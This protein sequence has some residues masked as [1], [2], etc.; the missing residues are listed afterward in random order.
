MIVSI[1]IFILI[2]FILVVSHEFGHF[3][4]AKKN[5]IHVTEFFVG[6][7]PVLFRFEKGGTVYSWR[8]FPIGGACVFEGLAALDD[9][10]GEETSG[11]F[12][13]A[14]VWARFATLLAGP[15]FN[16]ILAYLMAVIIVGTCGVVTPVVQ[17]VIEDSGAE[18]AGLEAGDKI[19]KING[20]HVYLTEDVSFISQMNQR[21]KALTVQYERAGEKYTTVVVPKFASE[22]GR[23]YMGITTGEYLKCNAGQTFQ[24]AF[25][26]TKYYAD[27]VFKSLEMLVMGQLTKDD[28]AGPVGIV[29]IVDETVD[30]YSQYGIL[31]VVLS[32]VNLVLA[33][34]VNLGIINLLPLPA[35]D[36]G[37]LLFVVVEMIRRKPVPVEKEGMVHL[38]GM[39]AFLI[40]TVFVMFNDITRFL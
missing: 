39:V 24:Y 13:K 29:K 18:A 7:G 12:Y 10:T 36:G 1:L 3:L 16:F 15:M 26:T 21:G 14:N 25:Y 31:E 40:L 9:N 38:V 20:K 37:R 33:L 22:E 35:V 27:A 4:L 23:Y 11:A 28:V 5:G 32:L 34:S 6:M 2:F 17:S 19:L 30:Y 8:L